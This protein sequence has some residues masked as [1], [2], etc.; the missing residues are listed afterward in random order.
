MALLL[1]AMLVV[2]CGSN[3]PQPGPPQGT[4]G[5]GGGNQG[6]GQGGGGQPTVYKLN[7]AEY[8]VLSGTLTATETSVTGQGTLSFKEPRVDDDNNYELV[9]TL[10]EAGASLTLTTNADNQL[11][12]GV[13]L[14]FSREAD[15]KLKVVLL[16]GT[17]TI[18]LTEQFNGM[19]ATASLSFPVDIHQH[20][21]L[22]VDLPEGA[23]GEEFNFR[24]SGHF[25]GLVLNKAVVTKAKADKPKHPHD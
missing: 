21:D 13:A 14:T 15:G 3:D 11:K 24:P 18:D 9:F 16:A 1:A 5:N 2:G 4:G 17:Q 19:A 8:S 10:P 22:I 23:A 20:G 6:G 7:G 12:N 25:W